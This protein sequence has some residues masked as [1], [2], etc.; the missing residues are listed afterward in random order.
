MRAEVTVPDVLG[1]SLDEASAK[2]RSGGPNEDPADLGAEVWA[3]VLPL[4]LTPGEPVPDGPGAA[5]C[6]FPSAIVERLE[7]TG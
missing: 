1:L 4:T 3:G 6:S 2:C 7:P 5:A